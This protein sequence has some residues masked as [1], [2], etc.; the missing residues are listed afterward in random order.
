MQTSGTFDYEQYY[1]AE[2]RNFDGYDNG[3]KTA[4]RHELA[5]QRTRSGTS[6]RTPYNAPGLLIWHR[7]QSHSINDLANNLFDPPS[8][9]SKGT[10]LLVDSHYEPA[11]LRGRGGRGQPEPDWTTSRPGS[12]PA[13]VAFGPV[14]RYPFRYC[15]PDPRRRRVRRRLQQLR[16]PQPGHPVHRR[17]RPGIPGIEYRPDPRLPEEPLFF[18][19]VDASTVVPSQGNEIYSTRI[20]DRNGR[21]LPD[22]VR[23]RHRRR[24]RAG[25][26]QPAGRPAGHRGWRSGHHGR[27]LA[28]RR[29]SR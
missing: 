19:D 15:V 3:L 8:I 1:L 24:T 12:R 16:H 21:L 28:R 23:H 10:V 5:G 9:G 2:W 6:T 27:P 13:D 22:A 26:R 20:V 29:A 7:D 17:P 14:G 25:H 4:V 18:R 11:R